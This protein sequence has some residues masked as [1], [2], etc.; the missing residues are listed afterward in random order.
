MKTP[1]VTSKDYWEIKRSEEYIYLKYLSASGVG[2]MLVKF[3]YLQRYYKQFLKR[4]KGC[5]IIKQ[6]YMIYED[7][8]VYITRNKDFKEGYLQ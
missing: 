3:E 4:L 6:V 5:W 7:G 1:R 2:Q 8:I